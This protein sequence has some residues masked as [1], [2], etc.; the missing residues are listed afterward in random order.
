MCVC[1][2]VCVILFII[3]IFDSAW[4]SMLCAFFSSCDKQGLLSKVAVHGHLIVV[5]SLVA[6]HGLLETQV[7]VVVAHG[8]SSWRSQALEHR[9][10]GLVALWHVGILPNQAWNPCLL[11]WQVN[12]LPLSHLG[13]PL[14][15]I[16]SVQF[17]RSLTSDSLQPHGL[18]HAR[19][20][21]PSPAPRV[22]STSCP[23]SQ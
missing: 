12:S 18:Q 5:A 3:F 14:E 13:S 19:P 23:V 2:C 11:H 20:P 1:V 6:E 9:C 10:M 22:H 7:S 17:S 4:P 15:G 16:S 21:C 8:L